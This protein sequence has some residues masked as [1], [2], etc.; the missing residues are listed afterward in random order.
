MW[1][2]GLTFG[3]YA[4]EATA[5]SVHPFSINH[6]LI[7][8]RIVV[9]AGA[10]PWGHRAQGTS[11]PWTGRQSG[12]SSWLQIYAFFLYILFVDQLS[13]IAFSHCPFS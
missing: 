9:G 5:P 1:P 11:T 4:V 13:N 8:F 2:L 6:H 10:Y 7:L 3:M 12:H